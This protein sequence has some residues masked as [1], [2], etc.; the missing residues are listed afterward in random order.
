MRLTRRVVSSL[1]GSERSWG[2]VSDDSFY[3]V[4]GYMGKAELTS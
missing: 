3:G 1:G 4:G 2:G